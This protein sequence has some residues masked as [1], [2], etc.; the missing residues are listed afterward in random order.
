MWH[1]YYENSD[2]LI[3]VLDTSDA[4]RFEIARETLQQVI[5]A[6]SMQK[7]PILILANKFD[8]SNMQP[9]KIVEELKL[10]QT[11]R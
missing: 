3:Y 11:R 10:H 4:D 7:C 9:V 8:I 1:H 6:D 5:N 2:A